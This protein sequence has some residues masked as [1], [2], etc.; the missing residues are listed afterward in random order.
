M[1]KKK[2]IYLEWQ[3]CFDSHIKDGRVVQVFYQLC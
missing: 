2:T 1:Q 3:N